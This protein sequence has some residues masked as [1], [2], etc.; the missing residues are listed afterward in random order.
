MLRG[1]QL[2]VDRTANLIASTITGKIKQV[3][4]LSSTHPNSLTLTLKATAE[5][6]VPQAVVVGRSEI[7]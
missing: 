7:T 5:W 2:L 1:V 6:Q 4:S 3:H